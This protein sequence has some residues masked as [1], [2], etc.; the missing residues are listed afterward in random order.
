MEWSVN[1]GSDIA[2][3]SKFLLVE[4]IWLHTLVN[5]GL[6]LE[7]TTEEGELVLGDHV[8]AIDDF[9]APEECS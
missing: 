6:S 2:A 7:F 8:S 9:L 5:E 1:V 4:T 3:Q